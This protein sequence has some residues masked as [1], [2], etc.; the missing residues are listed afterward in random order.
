LA[1]PLAGYAPPNPSAKR[2][3]LIKISIIKHQGELTAVRP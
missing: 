2:L 3:K 1:A